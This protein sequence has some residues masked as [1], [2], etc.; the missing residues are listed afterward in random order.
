MLGKFKHRVAVFFY[1]AKKSRGQSPCFS[2]PDD[3]TCLQRAQ[4][5]AQRLQLFLH[6]AFSHAISCAQ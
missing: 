5:L 3:I 2:H 6:D 1:A 4:Q